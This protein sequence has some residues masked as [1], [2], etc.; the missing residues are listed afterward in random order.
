MKK[1]RELI[2]GL[3]LTDSQV[4]SFVQRASDLQ[5]SR[6]LITQAQDGEPIALPKAQALCEFLS[7][8]YGRKITPAD[9]SDLKTI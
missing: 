3:G 5:I 7:K 8:E 2:Y 4:A 9:I 1:L 6:K